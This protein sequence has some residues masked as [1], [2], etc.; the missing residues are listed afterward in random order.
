MSRNTRSI[1]DDGKAIVIY[2][3][4]YD[5]FPIG[6]AVKAFEALPNSDRTY[7]PLYLAGSHP[8]HRRGAV[9]AWQINEDAVGE[10]P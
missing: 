2:G 5:E 8:V 3:Y 6:L 4:D 10:Q 7:G 1:W 9:C